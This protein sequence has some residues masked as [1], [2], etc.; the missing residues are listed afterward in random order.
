MSKVVFAAMLAGM[1]AVKLVAA[2]VVTDTTN[3]LY[4][5]NF[6]VLTLDSDPVKGWKANNISAEQINN[7]MRIREVGP[8]SYGSIVR[9]IPFRKDMNY[10]QIELGEIENIIYNAKADN[11][12]SSI[13]S[14]CFR[15]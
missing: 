11:A 5:E 10:L 13:I 1:L 8:K 4:I 2:G 14:E 7:C 12:S 15:D 3:I 6:K 9:Y